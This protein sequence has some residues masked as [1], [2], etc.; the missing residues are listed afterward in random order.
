ML[1]NKPLCGLKT[2]RYCFDGNCTNET[3][4]NKCPVPECTLVVRCKD[5]TFP[6]KLPFPLPG[7]E[8]VECNGRYHTPEW[9]CADGKKDGD[10]E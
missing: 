8:T 9:F 6:R 7:G 1:I 10:G 5:C 3:A 2:C 4:Y